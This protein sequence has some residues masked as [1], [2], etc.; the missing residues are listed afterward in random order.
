MSAKALLAVHLN[1]RDH[2]QARQFYEMLGF[3]E[4]IGYRPAGD[5][6][7]SDDWYGALGVSGGDLLR[8]TALQWPSDPYMH[9][10]LNEWAN[11]EVGGFPPRWNRLG[12]VGLSLLVD[13]VDDELERLRASG[14]LHQVTEPETIQRR[15]GKTR[16]AIAT[17][18]EGN[19]CELVSIEYGPVFA[20][21]AL[22]APGVPKHFVPN[23]DQ[24]GRL[25]LGA[26]KSWLHFEM[27]VLGDAFS[28]MVDFYGGFGFEDDPGAQPREGTKGFDLEALAPQY[29]EAYGFD[30]FATAAGSVF[31]GRLPR[32]PS[33]AHL[34]IWPWKELG[35][36]GPIPSFIHRGIV[37]FCFTVKDLPA[38]EADLRH[39]GVPIHMTPQW[40]ELAWGDSNWIY[41]ADPDG[42]LL[43]YEEIHPPR[44]LGSRT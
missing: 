15:W 42:N 26:E 9:L 40:G 41:F 39:R 22:A 30:M 21:E 38:L 14:S 6:R 44:T 25:A 12:S 17:D 27:N 35:E 8:S 10:I 7:H 34:E 20:A 32:D 1:V 24:G 3:E 13:D 19:F 36:P 33:N 18:P 23:W 29:L 5:S 43:C 11:P 28:E 31:M 16:A 37:R 4:S 2:D